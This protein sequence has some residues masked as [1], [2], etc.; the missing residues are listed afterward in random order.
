[1]HLFYSGPCKWKSLCSVR[2]MAR[3]RMFVEGAVEG[4]RAHVIRSDMVSARRSPALPLP[5]Q[6]LRRD[7]PAWLVVPRNDVFTLGQITPVGG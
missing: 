3:Q 1:M 2:A 4:V 7:R 6:F 5:Q